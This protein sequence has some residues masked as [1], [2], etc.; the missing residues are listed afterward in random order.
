[1]SFARSRASISGVSWMLSDI[2][3]LAAIIAFSDPG[4]PGRSAVVAGHL[5]RWAVTII[6]GFTGTDFSGG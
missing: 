5:A 3:Q 2:S 6:G 1:M 4:I